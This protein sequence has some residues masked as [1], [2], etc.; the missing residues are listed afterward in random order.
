MVYAA[1]DSVC[2]D[3]V[4]GDGVYPT[5]AEQS[6]EDTKDTVC[7]WQ[8]GVTKKCVNGLHVEF[9]H[10]GVIDTDTHTF[11]ILVQ[12]NCV[13]FEHGEL[14]HA[15]LFFDIDGNDAVWIDRVT[16]SAKHYSKTWGSNDSAG[17]CLS[18]DL[19][20]HLA[21]NSDDRKQYVPS[22]YCNYKI[23]L[24]TDGVVGG[25]YDG[26]V[27][28]LCRTKKKMNCKQGCPRGWTHE[29]TVKSMCCKSF[30]SCFG[31]N[32]ICRIDTPCRRRVEDAAIQAGHVSAERMS[33]IPQDNL[34]FDDIN[35]ASNTAD[36]LRQAVGGT[37]T[38]MA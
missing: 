21:W 37:S 7:V 9:L 38:L 11:P 36:R 29:S 12:P 5:D 22:G 1:R 33:E 34:S 18:T 24:Y 19:N 35:Q 32:K 30:W 13:Y 20:D 3:L 31:T 27:Q 26:S 10:T 6:D 4:V 17:V 14:K 25:W 8:D 2:F 28:K 16:V 15:N 23:V